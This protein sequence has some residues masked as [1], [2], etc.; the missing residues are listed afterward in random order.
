[1]NS[2]DTQVLNSWIPDCKA[3]GQDT[4]ALGGYNGPGNYVIENNYLEGAGENVLFGGADPPIPNLVTTNIT[5]RRNYL[6]K[7]VAWRERRLSRPPP[8][9]A[10]GAAQGG[11][12]LAAGTYSYK[13]VARAP[14]GQTTKAISSPSAEVS[15]T[16][17]AGATAR[18]RFPGS[19]SPALPNTLYS[20]DRRAPK[21]FTGPRR[22]RRLPT[23]APRARA[24]RRDRR[25]SGP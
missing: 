16:V 10:A 21:M 17:A 8:G 1:M 2:S 15:A 18:S 20:D 9:V 5:F 3:V 4:Q 14:A 11:G 24:A 22:R 13:V 6:S 12:T 25:P 19:R 7:P 23:K